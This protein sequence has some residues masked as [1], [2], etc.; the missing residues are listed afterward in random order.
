MPN[1]MLELLRQSR[2]LYAQAESPM[3]THPR[4]KPALK[5]EATE[6]Y[7]QALDM[8]EM[9]IKWELERMAEDAKVRID[10]VHFFA[11]SDACFE[12]R[13]SHR[14]ISV[15]VNRRRFFAVRAIPG[16]IEM[17]MAPEPFHP[18]DPVDW[19]PYNPATIIEAVRKAQE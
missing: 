14:S 16:T 10:E 8:R 11:E 12:T 19:Q 5:A 6:L 3:M 4:R 7:N 1:A 13:F 9:E 17:E 15:Y 2:E 18:I